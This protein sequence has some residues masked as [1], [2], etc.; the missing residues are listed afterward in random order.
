MEALSQDFTEIQ[1]TTRFLAEMT[2]GGKPYTDLSGNIV[3]GSPG[4][5]QGVA[6]YIRG[7]SRTYSE[8]YATTAVTSI[9]KFL[10][11]FMEYVR[12]N[13]AGED[14]RTLYSKVGD[15][16]DECLEGLGMLHT[17]YDNAEA[18]SSLR[19]RLTT[20]VS[21]FKAG[22]RRYGAMTAPPRLTGNFRMES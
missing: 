4:I 9:S 21:L 7:E 8:E 12:W 3:V 20:S 13:A 1:A 6:R 17:T 19:A 22:C 5:F 15:H 11:R 2:L 18:F 16:L 10:E 14:T